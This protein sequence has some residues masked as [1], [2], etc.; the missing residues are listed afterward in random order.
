MLGT[1]FKE[2]SRRWEDLVISHVSDVIALV[3][4]FIVDLLSHICADKQVMEQLWDNVLLEKLQDSYKRGMD[5]ARVLLQIEREGT[6]I[7]YNHYFNAEL[8]KGQGKRLQNSLS[9][10]A[11]NTA[12]SQAPMV[13]L[14]SLSSL[15]TTRSNP[16]QVREYLHDILESYYKVSV[17]RFVDVICQQV[18]DHFLVN[19]KDSPLHVFSTELVFELSADTLE[20]IAGE[21][22]A[23]KQE[24]ER[25]KRE[26]ER[27]EVAMKV[28]RG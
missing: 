14:A 17:K 27:L 7:T 26:I 4:H 22:Q 13:K 20:M 25:L 10:L 2:Q 19:G 11:I 21:D 18:I 28:L 24:R 15:N 6:P 3:H 9:S 12:D 16:E 8:Q 5:Q 1:T 23:T